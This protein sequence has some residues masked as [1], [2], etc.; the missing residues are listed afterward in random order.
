MVGVYHERISHEPAGRKSLISVRSPSRRMRAA[1]HPDNPV[2]FGGLSPNV[3]GDQLHG[4]RIA[5]FPNPEIPNRAHLIRCNVAVALMVFQRQ[6]GWVVG[7]RPEAARL[8]NGES[9]IVAN[10]GP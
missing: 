1:I 5:I 4:V 2:S 3:N 8:V 6:A 7:E 10:L 9:G